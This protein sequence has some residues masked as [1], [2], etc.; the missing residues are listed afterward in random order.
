MRSRATLDVIH[1]LKEK[2]TRE[3]T[4]WTVPNSAYLSQPEALLLGSLLP[5]DG[6]FQGEMA[7]YFYDSTSRRLSQRLD[8]WLEATDGSGTW[9]LTTQRVL[10]IAS[11]VQRFDAQGRRIERTESDGTLTR[12]I[13]PDDLRKL[14]QSKGLLAR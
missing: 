11:T 3:P 12:R 1:S 2:F 4:R 7:S 5:R 13:D 6:S 10:E 8:R 9:L 14:W